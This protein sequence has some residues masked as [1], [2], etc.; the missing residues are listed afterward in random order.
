M[1]G[2]LL[3]FRGGARRILTLVLAL[4]PLLCADSESAIVRGWK[5]FS[6]VEALTGTIVGHK[7]ALPPAAVRCS[8]CHVPGDAPAQPSLGPRLDRSTLLDPQKRR[9]APPSAYDQRRFCRILRTGVDPAYVVIASEMPRY[10]M[11][12][13]QCGSLWLYLTDPQGG[14]TQ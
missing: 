3:R 2:C 8:N 5:L 9:G 1:R 12:D 10:E 11:D 7:A 4:A 13:A 14:G 6:G